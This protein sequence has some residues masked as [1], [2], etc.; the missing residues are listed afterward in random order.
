MALIKPY[1]LIL[2]MLLC[3]SNC[4]SQS[5][6]LTPKQQSIIALLKELKI[7][8][9][10]RS[11]YIII[12]VNGCSG[13]KEEVLGFLEESNSNPK[14]AFILT[15]FEPKLFNQLL[16]GRSYSNV[17]FDSSGEFIRNGIV[18]G[19]PVLFT[20]SNQIPENITTLY[21]SRLTASLDSLKKVIYIQRTGNTSASGKSFADLIGQKAP[22]FTAYT[23]NEQIYSLN[24]QL[25][26]TVLVKFWSL[27]CSACFKEISDLNR[28]VDE[29]DTQ[30][31][32][33]ITI[34]YEPK[35]NVS[36][37]IN[38]NGKFYTLKKPVFGN[39]NIN[40]EII[41][42][43]RDIMLQYDFSKSLGYP[44]CFI[45]DKNGYIQDYNHGYLGDGV[46]GSISNY[47]Y[48]AKKIKKVMTQA[49]SSQ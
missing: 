11:N 34:I 6:D 14:T 47:D 15:G 12:P 19:F 32:E 27:T 33:L 46:G 5:S 22:E 18:N 24:K 44:M 25:G 3:L 8:V 45:I 29:L 36:E 20:I 2:I 35:G 30:K 9:K 48:L 13:C 4:S 37:K 49:T 23:L 38:S 16:K 28:L 40:Y 31:F 21:A 39:K 41:P 1:A 43:G 26:K 42:D 7:T 10:D 17:Y